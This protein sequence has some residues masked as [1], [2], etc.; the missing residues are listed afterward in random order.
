[1]YIKDNATGI[2]R[3]YGTSPHDSLEISNDGQ[4]L[5]YSNLQ[6]GENSFSDYRFVTD[7]QGLTPEEDMEI[8][9]NGGDA[10]FNI[11]GFGEVEKLKSRIKELEE[12]LKTVYEFLDSNF[13]SPCQYDFDGLMAYDF[14]DKVD[15]QPGISWCEQNCKSTEF[16]GNIQC[17]KRFMAVLQRSIKE[18][19]EYGKEQNAKD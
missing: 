5:I 2:V 3:L 9:K 16:K 1:M 7:E 4:Y 11:G 12:E 10:Y 8:I 6:N 17:W 18:Q 13:E 19:A 14:I 15:G